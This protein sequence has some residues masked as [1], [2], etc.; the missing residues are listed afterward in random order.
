MSQLCRASHQIF[1]GLELKAL[2]LNVPFQEMGQGV[3]LA[4]RSCASHLPTPNLHS[5]L[6]EMGIM[7]AT[8]RSWGSK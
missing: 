1:W 7:I 5:I 3:T 8:L 4:V 2:L 6:C